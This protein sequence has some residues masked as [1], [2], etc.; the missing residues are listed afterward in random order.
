MLGVYSTF[1]LGRQ[2]ARGSK[3]RRRTKKPG[4]QSRFSNWAVYIFFNIKS[5]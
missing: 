1:L 4:P 5:T 2:E 3:P